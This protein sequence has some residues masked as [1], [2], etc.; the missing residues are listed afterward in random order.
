MGGESSNRFG[1]LDYSPIISY[2]CSPVNRISPVSGSKSSPSLSIT[3][4]LDRIR[5]LPAWRQYISFTALL[6]LSS[7]KRGSQNSEV[8]VSLRRQFLSPSIDGL[9][10]QPIFGLVT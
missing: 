6:K 9:V 1:T 4:N 5:L 7:F 8:D 10:Y 3:S 2:S